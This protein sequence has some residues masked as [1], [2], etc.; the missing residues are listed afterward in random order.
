M[1]KIILAT[2]AVL[3]LTS[4]VYATQG[5]TETYKLTNEAPRTMTTKYCFYQHDIFYDGELYSSKTVTTT[6]SMFQRCPSRP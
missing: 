4:T 5:F 3:G 6:I 2:V 1:K